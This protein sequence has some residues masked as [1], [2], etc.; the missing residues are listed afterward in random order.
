MKIA[1][2]S[3][4]LGHIQRG[5]ESWALALATGLAGEGEEVTLFGNWHRC[6]TAR[7]EHPT[8]NVQH[9]TSKEDNEPAAGPRLRKVALGAVRRSSAL[10]RMLA[11]VMPGFTWRWGMKSGYDWEQLF[12]WRHLRSRLR[13]GAFDVLHLQD[14]MVALRAQ[15]HCARAGRTKVILA[16]GTE[17]DMAFLDRVHHVQELSPHYHGRHP[18]VVEGYT[19]YMIPNFVDTGVFRPGDR[20]QCRAELGL[21]DDKFIVLSVGA[22]NRRR[23]RMDYLFREFERTACP[24]ALLV[25]AGACDREGAELAREGK[26]RLGQR[27]TVFE[28]MP[29]EDMPG[30]YRAADVFVL[31]AHEEIFGIAFLEAMASGIPC[32]GHASPVTEWI[33]GDG[34]SCVDM[35][36]E[37]RLSEELS[38]YADPGLR[39]DKGSKARERAENMFSWRAVHQ[40][41]IEMY[42]DV[43]AGGGSK[44]E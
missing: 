34:G 42:R 12:F 31:C 28:N 43:M 16:H 19:R 35:L 5:V 21:P 6:G 44:D 33:V 25:V 8:P 7:T 15:R 23:K 2:A 24:N 37:N 13:N 41:F 3:S 9:P 38:K 11:C 22:V 10:A 14:P 18:A 1:I 30:L 29:Y 39:A 36:E 27:L 20:E 26:S 17:E 4:G 40:Q 32:I